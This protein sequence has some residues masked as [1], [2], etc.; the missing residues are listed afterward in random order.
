VAGTV[1]FDG[2]VGPGTS[3]DADT[4]R[5][6]LIAQ[7]TGAWHEVH[8]LEF[9]YV[10]G[11]T[12]RLQTWTPPEFETQ[13]MPG[14]YDV[15]YDRGIS[16][17]RITQTR[18]D[19][20]YVNGRRLL[21]RG[22][23]VQPG[24]NALTIDIARATVAGTVRIDGQTAPGTSSD[25]D[26]ARV[27]LIAEDTGTWHEV[28]SLEFAYVNG[29]T[30]RL[31]TWTP[32]EFE[33]QIM[34]G[35]Y[36]VMYDRGI[37]SGRITQT[38]DDDGYINGRRILQ[39]GFVVQPG[40]NALAVE[41]RA[42]VVAGQIAFDGVPAPS[43]SSDADTAWFHLVAR[44]TGTWHELHSLEFAYV[45]GNTYRLQT[46]TPPE[47][48]TRMMPG[49]YDLLFYRGLYNGRVTQTRDDD[50]YVNGQRLLDR[51]VEIP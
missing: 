42:S 29:N 17:E 44:D 45:N 18:D 27:Y 12:Y 13:I 33:T 21:Q 16:S 9:A 49:Q 11:N 39:R 22:L 40:A 15:M 31:Q 41:L 7:D 6:Y 32:P 47:F 1:K 48:A 4:A 5:V 38:R 2:Q 10:N 51:C 23:V 34:P 28:H 46:W 3:S 43:T 14:V 20:G 26:T 19:D 50:G 30:Y 24:A 36:D 8:S 35:V 37:Y 25:A